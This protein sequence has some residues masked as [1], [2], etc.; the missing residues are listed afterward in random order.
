MNAEECRRIQNTLEET[1]RK[2]KP[3]RNPDLK[4]ADLATMTGVTSHALSYFFNQ[5]LKK[6]Y[7]DYINEYRVEE[8]KRLIVDEQY[9]K[10]TLE[11]L[12]EVCGFSSRASFFR[13][14][15]KVAG[16]TPSEYIKQLNR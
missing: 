14:F 2:A 4:I 8:F 16:I 15:K 5:Y 13:Y 1:M 3:Y 10:Y 11:A 12:A 9:A 6:N 7:Y